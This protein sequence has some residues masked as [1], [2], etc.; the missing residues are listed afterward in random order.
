MLRK[1]YS[2]HLKRSKFIIIFEVYVLKLFNKHNNYLN[3]K[4]FFFNYKNI[5][6][7]II[8]I[9]FFFRFYN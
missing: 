3:R 8:L 5:I 9:S 7:S 4:S 2:F 6:Y 1:S